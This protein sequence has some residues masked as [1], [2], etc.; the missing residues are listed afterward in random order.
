MSGRQN[1]THYG[2][3]HSLLTTSAGPPGEADALSIAVSTQR[4]TVK[5]LHAT[6][7]SKVVDQKCHVRLFELLVTVCGC[8]LQLGCAIQHIP[9]SIQTDISD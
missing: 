3:L 7:V 6:N 9:P 8:D 4:L 2:H 1:N 5:A